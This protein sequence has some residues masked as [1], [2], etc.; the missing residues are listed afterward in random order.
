MTHHRSH[1]KQKSM[2]CRSHVK[3]DRIT[4]TISS[5]DD[6]NSNKDIY[7][8][9]DSKKERSINCSHE[10][11]NHATSS[12]HTDKISIQKSLKSLSNVEGIQ[13]P[14]GT[15]CRVCKQFYKQFLA[16]CRTRK[17]AQ[18]CKDSKLSV[19]MTLG[20]N[21]TVDAQPTVIVQNKT[22]KDCFELPLGT[23]ALPITVDSED[24]ASVSGKEDNCGDIGN[25][26]L[27]KIKLS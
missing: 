27:N 10:E 26:L 6:D 8:V 13:G 4:L 23:S 25:F 24:N 17:H 5:D 14:K 22:S 16:H 15:W 11:E 7:I 18:T 1:I 9:N 2:T 3:Q 12:D 21:K 19:Q 20:E